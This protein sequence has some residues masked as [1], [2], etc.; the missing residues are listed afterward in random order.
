MERIVGRGSGLVFAKAFVLTTFV[1]VLFGAVL[2]AAAGTLQVPAFWAYLG[3][4]LILSLLILILLY[5][6]SPDLIAERMRPGEGEQ[7]KVFILAA[8]LLLPLSFILAGFDVGRVHLSDHVPLPAQIAG[9]IAVLVGFGII[10]RSMLENRF[11]SSAVR[12]QA[13]RGQQVISSGPYAIVRHPG[14]TGGILYFLGSAL[15][16]G[17]WISIVPMLVMVALTLRRTALEDRMLQ[18]ELPGYPEYSARVRYRL[19]P[20]LW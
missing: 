6:R 10:A 18:R 11:F 14:Y 2:F 19:V 8:K 5:R 15:A 17:S 20:G 7:D 1:Y 13:D 3:L 9:F 12:M 4:M 16:L